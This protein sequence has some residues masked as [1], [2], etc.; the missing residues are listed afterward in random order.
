MCQAHMKHTLVIAQGTLHS[1]NFKLSCYHNERNVV[2]LLLHGK[3]S[4]EPQAADLCVRIVI[5]TPTPD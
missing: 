5:S 3:Q 2:Q 4:L 1:Q